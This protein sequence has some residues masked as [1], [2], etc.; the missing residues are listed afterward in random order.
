MPDNVCEMSFNA[1]YGAKNLKEIQLSEK[2]GVST[3]SVQYFLGCEK[4]ESINVPES[5]NDFYTVDGVLFK[6]VILMVLII[7]SYK[8]SS[9]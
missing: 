8:L 5:N 3:Y 4:L 7:Q 1:F 6:N 9:K 2:L